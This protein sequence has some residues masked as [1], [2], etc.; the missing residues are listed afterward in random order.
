M[1]SVEANLPLTL[2]FSNTPV[3]NPK[4][5]WTK[6][7]RGSVVGQKFGTPVTCGDL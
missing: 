4:P 7:R 1:T 6:R 2:L 5:Y 3:P